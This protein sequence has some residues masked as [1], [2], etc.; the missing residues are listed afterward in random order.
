MT[1]GP[2]SFNVIATDHAGNVTNAS[3]PYSVSFGFTGFFH[4]VD[5]GAVLNAAKAG[6]AIPL[7]FSLGGNFGLSVIVAGYPRSVTIACD[8]IAR[9][10][11][12]R[13]RHGR[14]KRP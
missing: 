6:S 7:K 8:A 4:P 11:N 12:R 10:R 1:T 14:I 13:D 3:V 2:K 5:N 9:G